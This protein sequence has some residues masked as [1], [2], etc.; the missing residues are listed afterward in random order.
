MIDGSTARLINCLSKDIRSAKNCFPVILS[1]FVDQD[2]N[3]NSASQAVVH[4]P[5]FARNH[6]CYCCLFGTN[7]TFEV[8][9]KVEPSTANL[10]ISLTALAVTHVS[11][12]KGVTPSS[13]F[14]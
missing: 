12:F 9:L 7:S 4:L 5:V 2:A 6:Y 11:N 14:G 8:S 13:C 3:E 10:A 1:L